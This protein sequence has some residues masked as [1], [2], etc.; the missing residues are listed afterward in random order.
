VTTIKLRTGTTSQWTKANPVLL[1]GEPGYDSDTHILKVGNGSTPW[2][3]LKGY[4]NETT[5]AATYAP[6]GTAG[7]ISMVDLGDAIAGEVDRANAEYA[8]N[9][10]QIW[11]PASDFWPLTGTE[12]WG[13]GGLA[14][15]HVSYGLLLSDTA[16][17]FNDSEG[18]SY[19]CK[20]PSNWTAVSLE[21][22]WTCPVAQASATL[23][24][25]WGAKF[26]SIPS[27][28]AFESGSS[29]LASNHTSGG[30]TADRLVITP[31]P[32]AGAVA[33]IDPAQLNRI[34]LYRNATSGNDTIVG[35]VL[36]LGVM[37]RRVA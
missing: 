15:P 2:M 30:T 17:T 6:G 36:F 9:P 11:V 7:T 21:V 24:A 33:S 19:V 14:V 20:F 13:Y 4:L 35:D 28:G 16:A 3:S 29:A 22:Y 8:E 25:S 37:V 18:G 12:S 34:M 1:L 31:L 32:G 23:R 26:Y 5:L 27:G 10:D